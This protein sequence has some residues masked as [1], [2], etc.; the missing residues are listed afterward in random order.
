MAS[1]ELDT[2]DEKVRK[3]QFKISNALIPI[4]TLI[5]VVLYG[6]WYSGGGPKQ[7]FIL[8]SKSKAMILEKGLV[9]FKKD[10]LKLIYDE[11]MSDFRNV[12]KT[13]INYLN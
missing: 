6:L 5:F 12:Y 10:S 8:F 3:D 9:H 1:T 13:I 2:S 7:P 4:G 11:N